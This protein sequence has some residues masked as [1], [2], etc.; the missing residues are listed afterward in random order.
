MAEWTLFTWAHL[1]ILGTL[2]PFGAGLLH[3]YAEWTLEVLA[4]LHAIGAL[5]AIRTA[6]SLKRAE[7][8]RVPVTEDLAV[9]TDRGRTVR[10]T[11]TNGVCGF[12]AIT[13]CRGIT[14][15]CSFART[16]WV[17]ETLKAIAVD[18]AARLL[19][20]WAVK[21]LI[22]A[23]AVAATDLTISIDVALTG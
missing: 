19:V 1:R 23:E 18:I 8:V 15:A 16:L 12:I 7:L 14:W 4:L 3:G 10:I 17:T 2:N 9:G 5:S 20:A 21:C 22:S 13:L 11:D 6:I